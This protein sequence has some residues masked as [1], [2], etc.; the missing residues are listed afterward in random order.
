MKRLVAFGDSNT[1]YW[2]GS[3]G[4]PGPLGAAWPARLEGLLREA[5]A[6]VSVENAGVPGGGTADAREDFGRVTAGA[7][8]VILAFGTNDVKRPEAALEGYT[9]D[10]EAIFRQNGARPLLALSILWFDRGYGFDGSQARLAPWNG[11][12]GALCRRHGVRFLDTTEVFAGHT[13]WYN[14]RPAHHL[15][16]EGQE[17]LARAVFEDWKKW[18]EK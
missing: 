15:T 10:L 4:E 12:A 5:G 1:R 8:A 11:A 2:L 13:A 14:D 17:R 9:A 7:D 3:K 18:S 6:E 16:A